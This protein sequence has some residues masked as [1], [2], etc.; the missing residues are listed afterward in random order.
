VSQFEKDIIGNIVLLCVIQDSVQGCVD[1]GVDNLIG[2]A[3]VSQL[4]FLDRTRKSKLIWQNLKAVARF[5]IEFLAVV[6]SILPFIGYI[7]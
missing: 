2:K 4:A 1:D 5:V 3:I 6:G 7:L